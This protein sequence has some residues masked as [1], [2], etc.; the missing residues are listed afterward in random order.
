LLVYVCGTVCDVATYCDII[1]MDFLNYDKQA[2]PPLP[3]TDKLWQLAD[4]KRRARGIKSDIV[5][6]ADVT[7]LGDRH[8][9]VADSEGHGI[10]IYEVSGESVTV[11]GEGEI[12][13]NSV[14]AFSDG[15]KIVCTDRRTQKLKIYDVETN[16]CI[17]EI[18][19]E[20]W[21]G[22]FEVD[23]RPSGVAVTSDGLIVTTDTIHHCV[24]IFSQ[25]GE[26]VRTF[27]G[28]GASIDKL[29]CPFYVAVDDDDNIYVSDNMNYSVKKFDQHG[30]CLRQIGSGRDWGRRSF[31][32][33]YGV[34]VDKYG[35]ILVADNG[36]PADA[37]PSCKISMFTESGEKLGDIIKADCRSPCGLAVNR[38]G[39][40]LFTEND[41][42]YANIRAY[43][44]HYEEMAY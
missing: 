22:E 12:W 32:C 30:K 41:A 28:Q 9:A 33:I 4:P 25:E 43:Q 19:D 6:P 36:S 11:L 29:Q 20:R 38:Q 5:N 1:K 17:N 27:G 40:M 34:A 39:V 24:K 13:P 21:E 10:P 14:A 3:K 2:P 18:D 8:F 16:K 7:F 44:I 23:M 42:D 26:V 31:Q 15:S 37:R 35:N